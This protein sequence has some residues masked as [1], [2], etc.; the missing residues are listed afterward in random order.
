MLLS[1][2]E[3]G[4]RPLV[5]NRGLLRR[6]IAITAGPF[7]IGPLTGDHRG[8]LGLLV[9]DGLITAQLGAGRGQVA[10][11]LGA[12]D[13]IRPW[14]LTHLPLAQSSEW[15]ALTD[16]KIMRIERGPEPDPVAIDRVLSRANRTTHWL[17]ATSLILSSPSIAERLLL[18]FALYG[19]RWGKVTPE[20]VRIKLP[21]THQLLGRLCGARR[22]TVTLA[23]KSLE[24]HGSVTRVSPDVWLLHQHPWPGDARYDSATYEPAVGMGRA[25]I[26]GAANPATNGRSDIAR[27]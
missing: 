23:I 1:R 19:E 16:A 25:W 14:E 15:R 3:L 9:C 6:E 26:D 21:L 8:C 10:W 22:P 18:L 4:A 2:P 24:E 13:L 27:M 12:G 5:P 20:G 7:E 11:L 17:L